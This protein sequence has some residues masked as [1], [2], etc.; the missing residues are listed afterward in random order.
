MVEHQSPLLSFIYIYVTW[1]DLDI[2]VVLPYH[3]LQETWKTVYVDF[4]WYIQMYQVHV[5]YH[6]TIR[7]SILY[8]YRNKQI[9]GR[10]T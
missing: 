6:L 3:A 7:E 8:L 4:Q 5:I 10:D 9:N 2:C 1:E